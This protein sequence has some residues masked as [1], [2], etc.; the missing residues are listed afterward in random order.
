[1]LSP[2]TIRKEGS[3]AARAVRDALAAVSSRPGYPRTRTQTPDV[4]S[5]EALLEVDAHY[6]N[7]AEQ[8]TLPRIVPRRFNPTGS[9]PPCSTLAIQS[10]CRWE[11]SGS[12]RSRCI[13]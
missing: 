13:S 1:M 11:K 7:L 12:L 5:V 8:G 3:P 2:G 9:Q 4:P 6:R 10:W